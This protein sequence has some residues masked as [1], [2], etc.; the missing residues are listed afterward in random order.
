MGKRWFAFPDV[1]AEDAK[2]GLR[3]RRRRLCVP[4]GCFMKATEGIAIEAG[5]ACKKL[6]AV[7][8]RMLVLCL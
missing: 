7:N 6:L 3:G 8:A 1:K 5:F 2:E 4:M